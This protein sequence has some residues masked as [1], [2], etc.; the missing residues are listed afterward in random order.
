MTNHMT[1]PHLRPGGWSSIA[2]VAGLAVAVVA[3]VLTI[4]P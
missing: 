4:G 2:V 3:A 1:G